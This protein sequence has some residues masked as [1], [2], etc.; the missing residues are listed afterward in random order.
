MSDGPFKNLRL[1]KR[2]RKFTEAAYNDAFDQ[3]EYCAMASDAVV[4]DALTDSVRALVSALNS[5]VTQNQMDIDP[6]SSLERIFNEH[7]KDQ[8]ADTLQREMRFHLSEKCLPGEALEQALAA[9][10]DDQINIARNRI[11][12]ECIHS[13]EIGQMRQD[14]LDRTIERANSAFESL[15]RQSI[16]EAIIAGNKQAFK[17]AVAKKDGLEEGPS[18]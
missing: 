6:L 4:Q 18:L 10:V 13:S 9:S 5:Y 17:G 15:D 12:E 14:Q 16:C 11:Q 2:W 3:I 8:F 1:T 7:S